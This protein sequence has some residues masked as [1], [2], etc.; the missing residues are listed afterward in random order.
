MDNGWMLGP[1]WGWILVLAILGLGIGL[2]VRAAMRGPAP[3]T[4]PSGDSAEEILQDQYARG[5]I[6]KDEYRARLETVRRA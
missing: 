5:E 1:G 4:P 3:P 6:G 2:A